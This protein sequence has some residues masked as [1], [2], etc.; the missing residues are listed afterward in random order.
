MAPRDQ[1]DD[2]TSPP[3]PRPDSGPAGAIAP[4]SLNR[5]PPGAGTIAHRREQIRQ[6]A[7][8]MGKDLA[9]LKNTLSLLQGGSRVAGR[10]GGWDVACEL[11]S[12][13]DTAHENMVAA[14]NAYCAAY[15]QVIKRLERT[16]TNLD[17]A[18]EE[19]T[20]TVRRPRPPSGV[21][22]WQQQ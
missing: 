20:H 16:A 3:L 6:V 1:P 4:G 15:D 7:R 13:L 19:A 17:K 8:E 21:K 14:V 22:P 18:E 10:V 11:G 5:T 2:P 9:D 12:G